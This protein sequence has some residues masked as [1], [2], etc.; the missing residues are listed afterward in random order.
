MNPSRLSILQ[1]EFHG[2]CG[3]T[4]Q[5]RDIGQRLTVDVEWCCDTT[6]AAHSDQLADTLDYDHL[7]D[8][9]LAIGQESRVCLVETLAE[10]I[11][12]RALLEPLALSVNV[13]IRKP[14]R[15]S[16]RGG[17]VV[18]ICRTKRLSEEQR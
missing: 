15:P 5:E 18:E 2:H 11:A 17:F 4:A 7:C 10:Q 16:M 3:V 12:Q 13:R 14:S 1:L 6:A 9:I 8:E